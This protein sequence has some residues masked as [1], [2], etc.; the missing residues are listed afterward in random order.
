[1]ECLFDYDENNQDEKE[2]MEEAVPEVMARKRCARTH[3]HAHTLRASLHPQINSLTYMF[4]LMPMQAKARNKSFKA[5]HHRCSYAVGSGCVSP[6]SGFL[7]DSND[8]RLTCSKGSPRA[9]R[10]APS[11]V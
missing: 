2:A 4:P 10:T 11:S 6:L 3:T 1:M 8:H 9:G 7:I 5:A